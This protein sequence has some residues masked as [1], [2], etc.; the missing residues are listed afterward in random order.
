MF[1]M[2][3]FEKSIREYKL[4]LKVTADF[5]KAYLEVLESPD[6]I[7]SK[8][9]FPSFDEIM[10]FLRENEISYGIIEPSIKD[11]QNKRISQTSIL[12][13]EGIKP[14]KGE[15]G[16]IS[17][18]HRVKSSISLNQDEKGNINFKELDWFI[19]VKEGE[20]L[21]RKVNPTEGLPGKN[22]KNQEIESAKGKEAVFKYGK[23]IQESD[24]HDILIASKSGRLEYEG[25]KIQ[26]NEVLTIKGSVDT[27][28]GN[29]RFS[30]DVNIQGD[31]KTGF[32]VECLGSLEVMGVI[33][34]SNVR[35][36]KDLVVK[37]GIQGN[38]RSKVEVGG[39][40]I[41]RFIENA[42]V[43]TKGDIITDFIVHSNV[44]CGENLTVKGK[45]GLIVGG[46]I[47]VKNE[48][49]AQVIG[50]YMGTKTSLEVGLDPA[51]KTKL[52]TY[53]EELNSYQ[54]KTREIQPNIE[55]GKEMLQRGLLDNVRRVSFIKM[56]EEYNKLL[57]SINMVE[58]EIQKI[59]S[60]LIESKT[61]VIKIKEKIY[62]GSKISIGR[63][64]RFIKDEIGN[65]IMFIDNNDITVRK[66]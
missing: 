55:T 20:V 61:G 4:S 34:A 22:I 44:S 15:D 17:F 10:D 13:A 50:S 51:D 63:Y 31:I 32:E 60:A 24:E 14:E 43:Y 29:I 58:L 40:L 11:I 39:K 47:R 35:V 52:E 53:K 25:D 26:I 56:L 3:S 64:T 6:E 49:S 54:R 42:M 19:E 48:I 5:M 37:G 45:K 30:G 8:S 16:Y 62:P 46:E 28:T 33:E 38:S 18:T 7:E 21:A 65:C 66:G 27:S 57:Q 2:L 23:N 12:I 59:E 36:G 9:D 1:K 41:C